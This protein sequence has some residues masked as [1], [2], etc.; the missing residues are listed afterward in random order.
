MPDPLHPA[1]VHF[2]I[3]LAVLLP[4]V[5]VVS[6]ILV[7]RGALPTRGWLVVP[8]LAVAL[9]GSAWLAVETG[10]DQEE[11]VESVVPEAALHDHEESAEGVLTLA[12]LLVLPALAG[13]LSGRVG[14]V[15]RGVTGVGAVV[16]VAL[17]VRTGGSGGELVYEYG[18]AAAYATPATG[19]TGAAALPTSARER[20]PDDEDGRR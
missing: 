17:V 5:V 11:A 12:G 15:A 14:S 10:E 6:W 1:I 9:A 20:E 4:F 13:L 2:P 16:L 19:S 3:V 7:H 8:V 18:A